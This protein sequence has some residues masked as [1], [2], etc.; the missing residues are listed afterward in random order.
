MNH[1]V[2]AELRRLA[3]QKDLLMEGVRDMEL[4]FQAKIRKIEEASAKLDEMQDR[5]AVALDTFKYRIERTAN[6]EL[7]RSQKRVKELEAKLAEVG[8]V[9]ARRAVDHEIV[10]RAKTIA[11]FDAIL[12]NICNW[13]T[14]GD[15][16]PDFELA[17]QAILFPAV[18]ERVMKGDEE[19]YILDEVP[20][21]AIEVVRRGREW[22]RYFRS[23]MELSLVDPSVWE[24]SIDEVAKWWT[25]DALP[26]IYGS[27]DPDWDHDEPYSL[28]E[29]IA[30]RDYPANRALSF[31]LIFD[32]MEAVNKHSDRIREESG[33]PLFNQRAVRTRLDP[34]E[35]HQEP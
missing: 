31:P 20:P 28:S 4:D 29:M 32:G 17:S 8:D 16:A 22:V 27:R 30:W 11:I 5:V 23:A 15:T 35:R 19:A 34:D 3:R 14:A 13:S 1:L 12:F 33:L 10:S 25:S 6:A 2:D 21:S 18:Y 7:K 24:R 9:Q 26:L